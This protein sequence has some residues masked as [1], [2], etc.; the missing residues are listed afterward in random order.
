MESGDAPH[1]AEAIAPTLP[2]DAPD[3]QTRKDQIDCPMCE[4]N[5]CGLTEPRCPE[6]GY[7]FA[8]KDL[9]DAKA[10]PHPYLFEHHPEANFKSFWKTA[11]GGMKPRTFW[12]E[13]HA[14]QRSRPWRLL[15]YWI[16]V[17]MP[18]LGPLVGSA[19]CAGYFLAREA[20]RH[21]LSWQVI[22]KPSVRNSPQVISLLDQLYPL[23]DRKEFYLWLW[24]VRPEFSIL[25]ALTAMVLAWPWVTLGLL[26]IFRISMRRA[27]VKSIHV[28]RAV[29]YCFDASVW[30]G[31]LLG[32]GLPL[33]MGISGYASVFQWAIRRSG[34]VPS[35]SSL[36]PPF[37][38]SLPDPKFM[39][40]AHWIVALTVAVGVYRLC[41]AYRKY[42]RFDWP[43]ATVLATQVMILLALVIVALNWDSPL[44]AYWRYVFLHMPLGNSRWL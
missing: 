8:W 35:F 7:R 14:G 42:L 24:S 26:M 28:I 31:V 15:I 23:P 20:G 9:L 43:I 25:A 16:G 18:S 36:R 34:Q 39:E 40:R 21:R 27:R 10:R 5:L 3:W 22:M 29:V 11:W 30:S 38:S 1:A 4:Y 12:S 13:L 44:A 6:C 2:A 19:L 37:F 41:V 32:I 33:I 17:G